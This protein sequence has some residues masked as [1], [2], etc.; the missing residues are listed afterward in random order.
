MAVQAAHWRSNT[1]IHSASENAPPMKPG[2]PNR[3]A[4]VLLQEALIATSFNIPSGPTGNYLGETAA[5]VRDVEARFGLDRDEGIAGK[6]V[7][8]TLDALLQIVAPPP[9]PPIPPPVPVPPPKPT[10]PLEMGSPLA[11]KDVPL[12]RRKLLAAQGA[13]LRISIGDSLVP[14]P[15]EPLLKMSP[16]TEA[17][18]RTHFRLVNGSPSIPAERFLV[19]SDIKT[20]NATFDRINQVLLNPAMFTTGIPVN[21][22]HVPAEAPFG[23]PI[24]FGPAYKNFDTPGMQRIGP[25]SRAAI[26]LHEATHVVDEISGQPQIHISEFDSGYATQHADLALHNPSSYAGFAAHIFH[27]RDPSPRFGLGPGARTL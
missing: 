14:K 18:L 8:G 1:R 22:L 23:G 13:L 15:G 10:E 21:G 12:A 2:D 6:Q 26:L 20:I 9:K 27:R 11:L 4:V 17:A 24:R 3:D 16:L 5:A 19:F 25:N 7:V